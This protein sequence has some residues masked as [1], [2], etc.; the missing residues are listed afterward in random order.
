MSF[1]LL[2]VL[3][4][5]SFSVLLLLA[6]LGLTLVLSLMNFVNLTHGT[7]FLLGGYVA[8]QWLAGGMAWWLAFPAAFVVAGAVG[9]LLDRLLFARFY[10]KTHLMQVLLT[11]GLSI[12]LAE[13]MR[14]VFG[15]ETQSPQLPEVL[16][17]AVWIA[18]LPFPL[19]RLVLITVASLLT[20]LLWWI[21]DRTRWGSIL[22]ACVT[23]R[24][25]A[26]TMGIDTSRVFTFGMVLA[27]ALSG[28]AGALGASVLSVHP[29]LDEEILL[30][31]LLVVVIG[32]LGSIRAT[33]LSAVV[34]GFVTTYASVWFPSFSNAVTLAVMT[35]LLMLRPNGLVQPRARRV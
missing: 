5:L 30:L 28:L 31:A 10:Q 33:V 23:D 26:E 4:A 11:Y 22:R 17:G 12:I 29:G 3:N 9:W 15:T 32:G 35:G 21:F 20:L 19:Y 27:A 25:M 1:Q 6:G 18:G 13:L 7:F 24:R 2:Q 14:I 8:V 16:D 34:I